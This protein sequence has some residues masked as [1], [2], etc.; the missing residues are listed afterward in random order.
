MKEFPIDQILNEC[1]RIDHECTRAM[2][3][4]DKPFYMLNLSQSFTTISICCQSVGLVHTGTLASRLALSTMNGPLPS[5]E[6][7]AHS[8]DELFARMF[9]EIS[10]SRRFFAIV[11]EKFK[12]LRTYDPLELGASLNLPKAQSEIVAACRCYALEENTACV[13]HLMRALEEALRRMCDRVGVK[14]EYNWGHII[15]QLD[16]KVGVGSTDDAELLSHLRAIKNA[17]RNPTMHVE[18]DYDEQ[19]ALDVLRTVRSF[20]ISAAARL[21]SD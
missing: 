8:M 1:R 7:I 6:T 21:K 4:S 15:A 16:K 2:R 3:S 12:Y 17:W 5:A 13:F 20:L 18:R 14:F 9:D 11:P 10:I 19:Q